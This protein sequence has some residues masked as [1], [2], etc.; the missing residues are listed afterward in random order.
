MVTNGK[1]AGDPA[2]VWALQ[3][4]KF[5]TSAGNQTPAVQ[6]VAPRY[7]DSVGTY[8]LRGDSTNYKPLPPSYPLRE[9]CRPQQFLCRNKTKGVISEGFHRCICKTKP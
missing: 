2:A 1:E 9:F 4:E 5:L 7:T 3:R 6:P 8:V